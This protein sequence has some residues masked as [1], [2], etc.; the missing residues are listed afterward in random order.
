MSV[1]VV[2]HIQVRPD[3]V[4]ELKKAWLAALAP[5][6]AEPGVRRY[7]ILQAED[8]PTQFWAFEE[9]SGSEAFDAHMNSPHIKALFAA[10]GS[11]LA[12]PP[13]IKTCRKLS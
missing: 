7:E 5:T 12:A 9:Y 8:D 11:L 1:Q 6:R 3:A 13:T 4:E 10:A 2:A